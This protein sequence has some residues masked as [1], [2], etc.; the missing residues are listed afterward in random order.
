MVALLEI[1]RTR[2]DEYQAALDLQ[3]QQRLEQQRQQQV[4]VQQLLDNPMPRPE[5]P[6]KDK[7]GHRHNPMPIK[8][9]CDSR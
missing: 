1:E 4:L 5:G 2:L 3:E 6:P 7:D 9:A 8:K